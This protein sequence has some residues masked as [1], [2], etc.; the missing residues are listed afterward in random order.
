MIHYHISDVFL[1]QFFSTS[2]IRISI[3][4]DISNIIYD[5]FTNLKLITLQTWS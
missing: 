2:L 5:H 3:I 1:L 4:L